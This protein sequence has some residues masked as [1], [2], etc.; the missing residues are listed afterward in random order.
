MDSGT[1]KI[2]WDAKLTGFGLRTRDDRRTWIIQYRIGHK[3]RRLTIG[4]AERLTMAQA[5]EAARKKLAQVE[6][7][8]DPAADKAQTRK[9]SKFTF[10]SVVAD[11]LA[12][13]KGKLRARTYHE[14]AR[15]LNSSWK[16]LHA[17][18]IATIVRKDVA[19]GLGK[20]TSESGVSSAAR[21]RA[22]LSGFFGWALGEGVAEANPVI[23]TNRPEEPKPRERVLSDAELCAIWNALPEHD[24]G[25][26]TRL[27]LLTGQR[28]EEI[29]GLRREEIDADKRMIRLPKERVKN[30]RAHEVPFSDLAW[31]VLAE[32]PRRI[33]RDFVFGD[34]GQGF[35]AWSRGKTALDRR[36]AEA[37]AKIAPWRLHDLRRTAATRMADIGVQ[38]HIIEAVLNHYSGHRAGV[39]SVYN[40]SPYE[41][42]VRA[43]LALW[44][45]HVWSIVEGRESKTLRR[46][47]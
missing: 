29:G 18:P 2:E 26:V 41:K 28:R 15:Y 13:R 35:T 44:A 16:S 46:P 40:K 6:L 23:G 38:P 32:Q 3:Q 25:R 42:D 7:G 4:K 21:A 45:D 30:G 34:R 14:V 37:G 36:L 11:Y 19:L 17:S 43:A 47:A 12:A 33:D 10:G 31:S 20:I 24:Y 27:L 5:R 9:D 8:I 22:A 39:A 1:D